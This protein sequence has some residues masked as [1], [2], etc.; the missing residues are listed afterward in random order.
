MLKLVVG[1][2]VH[3]LDIILQS[4]YAFCFFN[5][6]E[7]IQSIYLLSSVQ[8]HFALGHNFECIDIADLVIVSLM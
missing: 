1:L 5:S 2:V 6:L 3:R 7:I 8:F 4:A